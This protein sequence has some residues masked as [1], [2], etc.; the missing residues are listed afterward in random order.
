MTAKAAGRSPFRST[1]APTDRPSAKTI[2]AG[3][4]HGARKPAVR[5]R[6]VA[7]CGCGARRN[8]SASGIAVSSAAVRSQP[9]AVSSSSASSSESES[10][11]SSDS[12]GPAAR[13]ARGDLGAG[14]VG[15]S[16]AHLLAVAADRVD[17]AVVRDRPERL[18]EPPDRPGVRRVALVEDRVADATA[19]PA[20]PGR[21]P[22][23]GRR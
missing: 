18:G 5:R 14:R 21:G 19:A 2:A 4:S 23:A 8:P 11:P 16:A 10:E 15:G 9:V 3:P 22:A 1:R 6:N 7:T 13:S 17:L 12:S 20:G